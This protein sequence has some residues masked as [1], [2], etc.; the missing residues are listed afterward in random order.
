MEMRGQFHVQAF[1]PSGNELPIHCIASRTD[2]R[3][4]LEAAEKIEIFCPCCE[5][6]LDSFDFHLVARRYTDRAITVDILTQPNRTLIPLFST[7]QPAITPAELSQLI[8]LLNQIEPSFL[9]L[10]PL[11][12]PSYRSWYSYS[13]KTQFNTHNSTAT[14]DTTETFS[15]F[16]T[17]KRISCQTQLS[18]MQYPL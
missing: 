18:F 8:F 12:R 15:C 2:P 7:P 6:N 10:L 11:H 4:S 17:L 13:A 5:S 3:T 16:N 9:C 14:T 1:L